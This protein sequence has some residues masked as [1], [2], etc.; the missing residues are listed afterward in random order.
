MNIYEIV[1]VIFGA[2]C[3]YLAA[4]EKIL[5]WPIGIIS[6]IALGVMF[7]QIKLY[8]D[9]GEQVFYII[10]GFYGWYL[11]KHGGE[12]KTELKV[13]VLNNTERL[14]A[15]LFLIFGSLL[16]GFS[17]KNF[18]DASIPYLDSF[19][20]VMSLIAQIFL[21]T[22][23]FENWV[24]WILVDVLAIG[25]YAYKGVYLTAGLYIIYLILASTGFY[26]WYK[27][28]KKNPRILQQD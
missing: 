15:F 27:S 24:L 9:M 20:T 3:V 11:W 6:V 18:T 22:K 8:A 21:M 7:F 26:N 4:K 28:W 13:R 14:Q 10:T 17:L 5:N 23:V 16:M 1:G 12:K 19:T 2:W 25:I